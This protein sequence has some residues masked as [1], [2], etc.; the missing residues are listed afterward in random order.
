M[1]GEDE[2]SEQYW[3][4]VS[5]RVRELV[6]S[7]QRAYIPH[8]TDLLLSDPYAANK[9]FHEAIRDDFPRF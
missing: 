6:K 2:T 4:D 5:D 8:V 9:H 1:A 7:L 3:A